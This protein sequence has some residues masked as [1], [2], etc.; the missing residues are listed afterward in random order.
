MLRPAFAVRRTAGN[1]LPIYKIG[2]DNGTLVYT[3]IK[4]IKGDIGALS[5]D[6]KTLTRSEVLNCP[7]GSLK[8]KGDHRM[9]VKRYL[10]S[11]G[12]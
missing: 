3:V 7:D 5:S 12:F 11:L 6:L 10:E 8:L 1:Y 4:K 2:R 9:M